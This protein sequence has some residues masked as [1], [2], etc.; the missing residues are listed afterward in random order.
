[1]LTGSLLCS[2]IS[3]ESAFAQGEPISIK[4]FSAAKPTAAVARGGTAYAP[5]EKSATFGRHEEALRLNEQGV[6][7]VMQGH[8]E[9]GIAKIKQAL[10]HDPANTTILY[11]L[12]GLYLAQNDPLAA[13]EI[14]Q[15]ALQH[16]PKEVT[17]LERAAESALLA[18]KL[19]VALE[20]YSTLAAIEE[21][22][23]EVLLKLGTLHAMAKDWSKAEESLLKAKE[24]LDADKRVLKNLANVYVV[25][26]KYQEALPLLREVSSAEKSAENDIALAIA[27]EG[28]GDLANAI[29]HYKV[30]QNLGEKGEDLQNHILRLESLLGEKK[31]R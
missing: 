27:Y 10:A 8:Q 28:L 23:G 21:D 15:Q 1:M 2:M 5:S 18:N 11:N 25:Q 20:A 9:H 14:M 16:E 19:P 17:F 29:A 3:T 30:A 7:L 24:K 12:A 22:N 6:E 4:S 31:E 26:S 13:M